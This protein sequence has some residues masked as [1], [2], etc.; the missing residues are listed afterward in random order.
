M[1]LVTENRS[2]L[3]AALER[4]LGGDREAFSDLWGAVGGM[5]YRLC[6]GPAKGTPA[7]VAST[8]EELTLDIM[9]KVYR[10]LPESSFAPDAPDGAL[11]GWLAQVTL[12]H[13]RDYLSRRKAVPFSVL[14]R[15]TATQ[16]FSARL[17]AGEGKHATSDEDSDE[18]MAAI[19]EGLSDE[20]NLL[21]DLRV[22]GR[23]SFESIARTLG[24]EP[25]RTEAYKKQ[26]YRLC[27]RIQSR[28]IERFGRERFMAL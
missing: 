10:R 17:A 6:R 21:L 1:L 25:P 27:R 2:S 23:R 7:L 11:L 20:E 14:E 5:V 19:H 12:N 13:K 18:V 15:G 16:D 8:A 9:E 28:L 3:G 24:G 26:F 22:N 4:F